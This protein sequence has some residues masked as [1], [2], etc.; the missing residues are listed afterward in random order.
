MR[1][2]TPSCSCFKAAPIP[3][4]LASEYKINGP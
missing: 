4:R 1:T 3:V 2:S